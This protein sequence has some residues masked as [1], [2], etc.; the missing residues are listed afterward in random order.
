MVSDASGDLLDPLFTTAAMRSVFSDRSR[1]QAM[2]DFEA[3]LAR[4]LASAGMIPASAA[5]GI[6]AQCRAEHYDAAGLGQAAAAAGNP[7]IPLVRALTARVAEGDAAAAGYV[8]WG[9]TSQD[10]MDT[11]LV[12]QLRLALEALQTDLD[13]FA[14]ALAGL[15]ERHRHSVLA[16]RTWLQ[17]GPPVSFGLKAAGWLSAVER[18]RQRLAA[19]HPGVLVLQF[20]GAVGTLASLGDR[21][22]EVAAAL[23]RELELGLPALP[24]HTH[25][26]N[27]GELAADLGLLT[28]TLGKIARDISLLMQTEVG[29][30][31]EPTAPG[32]GGSST[33]P[34]K[35]NPVSCAVALSAAARVPGLVATMLG[36]MLQE[37]ER[38]LGTWQAEWVTLPEICRLT[39]GALSEMY[40]AT[41]GLDVRVQRMQDNLGIT[42][43]LLMAESVS[44]AL[45]PELGRAE[46]HRLVAAACRRAAEGGR[47][48]REVLAE[49]KTVSRLLPGAAL[50]RLLDPAGYLGV[51]GELVDRVLAARGKDEN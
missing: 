17:Q 33:M 32:R 46:A 9:A 45:A 24:W 29:E 23:A 28:G 6:A 47:P 14:G 8:H 25:R 13:G 1:L 4:A 30:V 50:D 48:L 49:E 43:G 20:G 44:T 36:A 41:D 12:L 21:G 19:L 7:A 15:A 42:G 37:H 34:H 31:L 51:A 35:R 3:A 26:D 16:G 11:G 10:V 22:L 39:A 2:L 38:G 27:L 5:V 40:G 18:H